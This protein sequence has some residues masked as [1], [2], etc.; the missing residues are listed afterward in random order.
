MKTLLIA[1]VAWGLAGTVNAQDWVFG[2]INDRGVQA[3]DQTA[4]RTSG[5]QRSAWIMMVMGEP[6]TMEGMTV[7]Y[8]FARTIFDCFEGK[9]KV[10]AMSLHNFE[11][12]VA[13]FSFE[14]EGEWEFQRPGSA[15]EHTL[16]LVCDDAAQESMGFDN[17]H[18]LAPVARESLKSV[19]SQ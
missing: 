2:G 3:Y 7:D 11:D 15:G 6:S 16:L 17:A 10:V 18:A 5:N 4:V 1:L 19:L 8:I 12:S 9:S 14:E 13:L